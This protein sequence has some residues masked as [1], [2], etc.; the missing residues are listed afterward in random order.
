MSCTSLRKLYIHFA[1]AYSIRL[2]S[3]V[4]SKLKPTPPSLPMRVLKI[5]WSRALSLVCEVALSMVQ[6][7]KQFPNQ[8]IFQL[9]GSTTLGP[10]TLYLDKGETGEN[11]Y[12]NKHNGV[13][14]MTWH[15]SKMSLNYRVIVERYPFL[16]GMVGNSIHVVKS[17]LYLSGGGGVGSQEP[18][19]AM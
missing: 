16:N 4:R 6:H 13:M 17:S 12:L 11:K 2:S 8:A 18:T 10:W 7:T 5:K 3:V 9:L 15:W 1:F 14:L 19:T